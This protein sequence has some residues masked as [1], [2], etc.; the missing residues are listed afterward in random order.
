MV[1]ETTRRR[2]VSEYCV[3]A[4]KYT[5]D[6][7]HAQQTQTNRHARRRLT[8]AAAT[9]QFTYSLGSAII[10][11]V[12]IVIISAKHTPQPHTHTAHY[13]ARSTDET[14]VIIY[15]RTTERM[16]N[17]PNYYTTQSIVSRDVRRHIVVCLLFGRLQLKLPLL[18]K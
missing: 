13:S 5:G 2:C 6:T 3:V 17:M 7:N 15:T 14:T 4:Q 12:I 1:P 11:A 10:I 9:H 8:R 16:K 18:V